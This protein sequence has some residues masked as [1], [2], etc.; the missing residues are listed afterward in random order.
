M[1]HSFFFVF[2]IWR[3]RSTRRDVGVLSAEFDAIRA[4]LWRA[5]TPRTS[6]GL[7]LKT[8]FFSSPCR[9]F[10][11]GRTR[12]LRSAKKRS[13]VG[14]AW[15]ADV[16]SRSWRRLRLAVFERRRRRRRRRPDPNANQAADPGRR[17]EVRQTTR[18]RRVCEAAANDGDGRSARARRGT[19]RH[20]RANVPAASG[21]GP[22]GR[23]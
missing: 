6:P 15:I 10:D 11:I 14:E 13:P 7:A 8:I 21:G 19:P 18:C 17:R 23:G 22:K 3:W 20:A 16:V 2:P 12:S 5:T 9:N 1:T 4:S